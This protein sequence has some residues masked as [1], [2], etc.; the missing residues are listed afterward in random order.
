MLVEESL[1]RFDETIENN[2]PA[3][4]E[5]SAMNPSITEHDLSG[6]PGKPLVL[7]MLISLIAMAGFIG[8]VLFEFSR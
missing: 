7:L 3:T 2:H 5:T 1:S 6:L 8:L 4:R